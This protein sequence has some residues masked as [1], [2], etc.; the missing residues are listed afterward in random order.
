M[1]SLGGPRRILQ[2][3][4]I[5]RAWNLDKRLNYIKIFGA[6]GRGWREPSFAPMNSKSPQGDD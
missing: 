1:P 5:G 6:D 4:A 3:N 2:A